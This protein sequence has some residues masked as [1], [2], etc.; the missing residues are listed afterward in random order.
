[1]KITVEHKDIKIIL[2]EV[3]NEH[4][5]LRWSDQKESIQQTLSKM[6]DEVIRLKQQVKP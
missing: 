5:T 1:M 3:G 6:I 2:E 4:S